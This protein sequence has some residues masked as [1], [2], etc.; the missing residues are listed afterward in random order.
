MKTQAA[1]YDF[2]L[3]PYA[4]GDVLTWNV[5]TAMAAHE[6]G[7]EAC[8]VV[9]L[10]DPKRPHSIFQTSPDREQ[11]PLFLTEL[12]PAFFAHPNAS[13]FHF[14]QDRKEFDAYVEHL[15]KQKEIS[16]DEWAEHQKVLSS[17]DIYAHSERYFM[18]RICH[19]APINAFFQKHGFIPKLRCVS[20]CEYD[21]D[22]LID[23]QGEDSVIVTTQFRLRS[24]DQAIPDYETFRNAD[25]TAWEEFFL[26]AAEKYPQVKFFLL[27]RIQEK[28]MRIL[29]LP[30]V[31]SPRA[32]G[33]NLGHEISL[34]LRSDFYLGSSSGFAQ[35]ANFSDTPYTIVKMNQR[36]CDAYA[37]PF[38]AERL[39]F[40]SQNQKLAYGDE[41]AEL[42]LSFLEEHLH[43]IKPRASSHGKVIRN[44]SKT[45]T[46]RFFLNGAELQQE[47]ARLLLPRIQ[48]AIKNVA[49][50]S[51]DDAVAE[52]KSIYRSLWIDLHRLDKNIQENAPR[53][54]LAFFM[55]NYNHGAHLEQ[56]FIELRLQK[57]QPDQIIVV[58][59]GSTD[60]SQAI[61][62]KWESESPSHRAIY[63]EKN[64]GVSA[65]FAEAE[66]QITTKYFS[67]RSVDDTFFYDYMEKISA[68][69]AEY[70]NVGLVSF[71]SL[72][73]N[74]TTGKRFA[75]KNIAETIS[76][77]S[78]E[79]AEFALRRHYL[80]DPGIA[81]RTD[82][83]RSEKDASWKM[84]WL[85]QLHQADVIALRHGFCYIPEP[86]MQYNMRTDSFSSGG[87]D[88][89]RHAEAIVAC[90][91]DLCSDAKNDIFAKCVRSGFLGLRENSHAHIHALLN[92]PWLDGTKP[93]LLALHGILE[94]CNL[95]LETKA[96]PNA[97]EL[98]KQI[99][100]LVEWADAF[101]DSCDLSKVQEFLRPSLLRISAG[102]RVYI[103][104]LGFF[105]CQDC[106]RGL[107]R[108]ANAFLEKKWNASDAP[109]KSL[110]RALCLIRARSSSRK[111]QEETWKKAIEAMEKD[112][113]FG[114]EYARHLVS[115]NY[116]NE[117]N[118]VADGLL[119]RDS[120]KDVLRE[121]REF[122][123]DFH[124][125]NFPSAPSSPRPPS[126]EL[127]SSIERPQQKEEVLPTS[128]APIPQR[129]EGA[130]KV[131]FVTEK[132]AD[133]PG[134]SLT[135]SFHNLFGS[136][137]STGFG[138]RDNLFIE[139][140]ENVDTAL[141]AR[142][143]ETRP[144]LLVITCP[145]HHPKTPKNETY[146]VLKQEGF[147]MAF[148]WW[149]AINPYIMALADEATPFCR[150]NFILDCNSFQRDE[151]YIALWTPQD[152]LV[153][154]DPKL[155]RTIDVCFAGSM[156]GHEE[157]LRYLQALV[158]KG[159]KVTQV[160]GQ[161]EQNLSVEDYAWHYQKAKIAVNFSQN[162][163]GLY[164][165]KGR[166]WE[167][168]ACG[169]AIFEMDNAETQKWWTPWVDYVP[170]TNEKELVTRV[171]EYLADPKK[172]SEIAANAN[173]KF[174]EK[175][176]ATAWWTEVLTSCDL[177]RDGV[178]TPAPQ[179][180]TP[181]VAT[182]SAPL[183]QEKHRAPA[184]AAAKSSTADFFPENEFLEIET[185][186]AGFRANPADPEHLAQARA[187]RN[188]IATH[189][190]SQDPL[191]LEKLFAGNF[192]K[193]FTL[194]RDCGI[195]SE[196]AGDEEAGIEAS[197][198]ELLA[199]SD[200]DLR[201][202]LAQ[203]LLCPAHWAS[204]P[205]RFS[206]KP[207]WFLP[208]YLDYI[209]AA[210]QGFTLPGEPGFYFEHLSRIYEVANGEIAAKRLSESS[211][212]A[213]LQIAYRGNLIPVYFS[214]RDVKALMVARAK[215]LAFALESQGARLDASFPPRAFHRGKIRVGF[216]SAHLGPQ[217]ET[218][219]FI[220][221]FYLD[222]N[223]FEIQIFVTFENPSPVESY[224][225]SLADSF[226]LLPKNL[227]DRVA[228][229][230]SADLDV[231]IIGTNMTAVTNDVA[232]LGMHRLAPIQ[233]ASSCSPM[234]P[235][236]P[237]LDGFLSGVIHGYDGYANHFNE[238]LLLFDGALSCLEYSVD[239]AE[240]VASFT[241]KQFGVPADA[242]LFVSGANFFKILPELQASWAKIL[243]AVPGSYLVLHPFN[244]NWTDSYPIVR[245]RRDI[246]C[247]FS[248]AGVDPKRV[249]ISEETLPSRTDVSRLMAIGDVYLDSHPFSGSVSLIDPLSAAVPIVA[250][251]GNSL[252]ALMAASMLSD[253]D[254][255]DYVA[256][257]EEQ[258]IATA[259]RLA[260]SPGERDA[261][262]QKI[263]AAMSGT[264]RFFDV[265]KYGRGVDEI[266]R[267]IVAEKR[268]PE[269]PPDPAEVLRRATA[270][271]RE[272]RL[273]E[274]EDLCRHLLEREPETPDA[275]AL[276]SSL[277]R[278]SGDLPYAAEL[279]AQAIELAPARA[280]FFVASGEIHRD[281]KD[282][283]AALSAFQ[284]ALRLQPSLARAWLGLA[285]LRD[286]NKEFAEAEK[287]YN[288]AVQH[289]KDRVE[290][291]EIRVNYAGFLRQ[292]NRIKEA[293]KH[294]RKA[295]SSTP[296][297][298]EVLIL[299]C[300]FLSQANEIPEALS[301]CARAAQKFPGNPNVWLQWG[302][303][304][305]L[306]QNAAEAIE[307][308]RKAVAAD[309]KSGD[310]FFQ[311]GYALQLNNQ[312]TEALK[313]YHEAELL[314]LDTADL[315]TNIG[316]LYKDSEQLMDAV[317][318]FSMGFERNPRSH[319]A[320]NNLG[321]VCITMGFTTEAIEC[322]EHA[323]RFNPDMAAAY[324][325]LGHMNKVSGKGP[326]GMSYYLKGLEIDPDNREMIHNMLLCT[327]YQTNL[328]PEQVFREHTKW[329]NRL[330]A[331]IKR[332]PRRSPF[333]GHPGGKI[334][335]GYVSPDLCAHPVASFVEPLFAN[336]DKSRFSVHVFS[337][338]LRPDS[339][340]AHLRSLVEHWHDITELKDR[341]AG[342]LIQKQEI[343]ILV[344]LC[345]HTGRN[346]LELFAAKPAP[347]QISYL[348]YPATTGIPAMGFRITDADADPP[349]ATDSWHSE[350]L[351]RLPR[352]AWCFDLPLQ[353]PEVVPPPS[354]K[355]GFITFGC[356]NNLAKHNES[357]YEIWLK[358][359]DSTPGSRLFLKSKTLVDPGVCKRVIEF[360]SSRGISGERLRVSGFE[361]K[362][363]SHLSRYGEV[364][365]AL[366][367]YPY[368]GTTTTCEALWMG[369]PVITQA[370]AAHLS[371]VGVSLL[372]AVG[373]PELI[374]ET[375]EDYIRLACGLAADAVRLRTL[376][377]SLR[378]DMAASSLRD[379]VGFMQA[380]EG[381]YQSLA[382]SDRSER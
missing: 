105:A 68:V 42:L 278:K 74:V 217:T 61:I 71:Q 239:Q 216:L 180:L 320:M 110:I 354:E 200:S 331:G 291:S 272:G 89:F 127:A 36:A 136:F 34:L 26:R 334:R 306:L 248:A 382:T 240:P 16:P 102:T 11:Y 199:A 38:G 192:S 346:R 263:R 231:L 335:V 3:F 142:C 186:L 170:F 33:L 355:A 365:I 316:V 177:L 250:W 160:G 319:A 87:E 224:C 94:T 326:E 35:L 221:T 39:P 342:E 256:T 228:A 111:N 93:L 72:R 328:T 351:V 59:D 345:G 214:T 173:R 18:E 229:L 246:W 349:G 252:R 108:D 128:L 235:G 275:W 370:G 374:A 125:E 20:G 367:T 304:Y 324:N 27:G 134:G 151:R 227:P 12:Q 140:V 237:H 66:K 22:A 196:N 309:P 166:L 29:S 262:R 347:I 197:A 260:N 297:S 139:E 44:K 340:T 249:I 176:N 329:G 289:S 149:D 143:R 352:C 343:D 182:T 90:V 261:V 167:A 153:Y 293:V 212:I 58:D 244:P 215:L 120:G 191:A 54:S 80:W 254:L 117:A 179:P 330:V 107:H 103:D 45:S 303:T 266:L 50:L 359:L 253:L 188:G 290:T 194:L 60:G 220:P 207:A 332:F 184:T 124:Q 46:Y 337:D 123:P 294:L 5:R 104:L 315:F 300:E 121:L 101:D 155:K 299:L 322:F 267:Q 156:A 358:I 295:V 171:K 100:N 226:T 159:V 353:C 203:M 119:R 376:R 109:S 7:A 56:A 338:V 154:R 129:P 150:R 178:V 348:G 174:L 130:L 17:S 49:I 81:W 280:D 147:V 82:A 62:K 283:P 69:L 157:R 95:L 213:A 185:L 279:L 255:R 259:V 230:R 242:T 25:P 202:L 76:H 113:W 356:F 73:C 115:E 175:Y 189:I 276:L 314:G 43:H 363:V 30:N 41:T 152:P 225:R 164:Q 138:T 223:A 28:P 32:L 169:A 287:A 86:L 336:C 112:V 168:A 317:R 305:L 325:N 361:Q 268:V 133:H 53:P 273:G 286:D 292:Q 208:F 77:F 145:T 205:I 333:Q 270:A 274:T 31:I 298:A 37:I 318:Y 99:G 233:I 78:P 362:P 84:R 301:T 9:V 323:L 373:H 282:F 271:F 2:S 375:P 106:N 13:S 258:Y 284:E 118:K 63:L 126:P 148:I 122:L 206:D 144:D 92:A 310:A 238:R 210:P 51:P 15:K 65:A 67:P 64:V 85:Q 269:T 285:V 158:A 341:E 378:S 360:F 381:A 52:L 135:N 234:T 114:M 308:F 201:A 264:P 350:K 162:R 70:P 48:N 218:Y 187:L 88:P 377:A 55:P 198:G 357:L 312:R 141:L 281:A 181:V 21:V 204:Y 369:V 247:A 313:A 79:E 98:R 47:N 195:S 371:R 163:F 257:S 219:V 57:P 183:P 366:D 222:R 10:T 172:L 339:V 344:D 190:L 368:H 245:F 91:R 251:T 243:L 379:P 146:A 14:F 132:W 364:D 241:R 232:L 116:L 211:R 236:M 24:L 327:L 83:F 131:L 4:L 372:R 380:M 296:D 23:A 307:K 6:A 277:A 321:A 137:D 193:I 165:T 302:K 19:Q 75:G 161:R 265:R 209:L 1:I 96:P 8:K 40:A 288:Q 311:L 97:P